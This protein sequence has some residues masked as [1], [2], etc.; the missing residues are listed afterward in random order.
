MK[1]Y[2]AF[3]LCFLFVLCTFVFSVSA[4][5]LYWTTDGYVYEGAIYDKVHPSRLTSATDSTFIGDTYGK[6]NMTGIARTNSSSSP[7]TLYPNITRGYLNA[8]RL[9]TQSSTGQIGVAGQYEWIPNSYEL[10]PSRETWLASYST[11][12]CDFTIDSNPAL[13]QRRVVSITGN[14]LHEAI[15]MGYTD[16]GIN[17]WY[18][19]T[20]GQ[21]L[22]LRY[23]VLFLIADN[24]NT[25]YF[26]EDKFSCEFL[27]APY[28]GGKPSDAEV[29][30]AD[31]SVE[32]VDVL[33]DTNG[34]DWVVVDFYG[35]F[36]FDFTNPYFSDNIPLG[37]SN[38]HFTDFRVDWNFSGFNGVSI[39]NLGTNTLSVA[40]GFLTGQKLDSNG[41]PIPPT[42]MDGTV[43]GFD[44]ILKDLSDLS[45]F[46][47]EIDTAGGWYNYLWTQY[48]G[49]VKG[50]SG[51]INSFFDVQPFL[52]MV[53]YSLLFLGIF[54]T[55][56]GATFSLWGRK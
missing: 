14:N 54:G 47:K 56:L 16:T 3:S 50:F 39:P 18:I 2:F 44:A 27:F 17:N 24:M 33:S 28:G 35:S 25:D 46:G 55:L 40:P 5:D 8:E 11:F 41:I 37:V 49:V 53:V 13:S 20:F 48:R 21:T 31:T 52:A 42:D 1:R 9:F 12:R 38:Y 51:F 10:F 6:V 36:V 43:T 15:S 22:A 7:I 45:N 32:I 34:D 26:S 30:K 29:L 4:A 19:V 23:R